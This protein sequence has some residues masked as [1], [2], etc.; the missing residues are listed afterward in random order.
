MNNEE[1]E[2]TLNKGDLFFLMLLLEQDI[3]EKE[4]NNNN[5]DISKLREINYLKTIDEKLVNSLKKKRSD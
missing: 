3:I 1:I 5:D 2:I 4:K